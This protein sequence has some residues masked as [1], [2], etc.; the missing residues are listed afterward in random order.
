MR[1]TTYVVE[2]VKVLCRND[3][4]SIQVEHM[5]EKVA[6]FVLL[7]V[8]EEIPT[9]LERGDFGDVITKPSVHPSSCN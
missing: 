1:S 5:D 8:G 2:F 9:R 4:V 6:E 7:E 3:I